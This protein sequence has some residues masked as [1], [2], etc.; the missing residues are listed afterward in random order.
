MVDIP[1]DILNQVAAWV[2]PGDLD[3]P[4][5]KPTTEPNPKMGQQ[6]S[7]VIKK[8]KKPILYVCGGIIHSKA[9]SELFELATKFNIPVT[10]PALA[11]KLA[12]LSHSSTHID[13][14]TIKNKIID[15]L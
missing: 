5:Y 1:K 15:N 8:S 10:K 12:I 11:M 14:K 9:N 3:L 6:A 2:E 7:S 4:G 13:I